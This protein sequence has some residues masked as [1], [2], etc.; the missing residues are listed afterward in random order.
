MKSTATG[1]IALAVTVTLTM[2]L[3]A[4]GAGSQEHP[5]YS[6]VTTLIYANLDE[7]S[8]NR[9][10]IDK[11]NRNH[12]NVQI[13]VRDYFEEDGR[14]SKDRLLTEILAGR[15]PDIID[16]GQNYANLATVKLPYQILAAKGYLE[17][18]WPYIEND[19]ELGREGVVEAPLKAAE[20]D[21]GLYVAFSSVKINTLAGAEQVV[22]SGYSWTLDELKE[23]FASM[24]EGSSILE[25]SYKKSD[26][27]MFLSPMLL[28]GYVDCE[29]GRC[30]F[31][32][33]DFRSVLTFINSFPEQVEH[34]TED[35]LADQ[36]KRLT[37]GRQMLITENVSTPRCIQT[38]DT[39]FG[40]RGS[41]IGYPVEDGSA[42]SCFSLRGTQLAISS[43]CKNKEA[44]WE[45][46]RQLLLPRENAETVSSIDFLPINRADFEWLVKYSRSKAMDTSFFR[47][48]VNAPPIQLHKVTTEELTRYEDFINSI[49]KIQLYDETI[50]DIVRE[51]SYLYFAG[52]RTLDE[53]TQM[54][55]NRV[56]LYVNENR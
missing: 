46:V 53:T 36:A 45:F 26:M 50:Y 32:S 14:S 12:E 20:V 49:D 28:D 5:P 16:L 15:I 17:D 19:P 29:T 52:D 27:F 1:R 33:E 30:T 55:Q 10:A 9:E 11:F 54:I 23:A 34:Y 4:C 48:G 42:G 21:G 37:A 7:S 25:P 8:I 35:M 43:A 6:D 18:L 22:G 3:T 13:E 51:L 40:G 39:I 2:L 38:I 41:I 47:F 31:D 24:P 56:Q 44:A